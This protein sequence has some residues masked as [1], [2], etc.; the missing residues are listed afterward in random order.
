METGFEHTLP[1]P[2]R[3]LRAEALET[4]REFSNSCLFPLQALRTASEIATAINCFIGYM[5]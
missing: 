5:F 4:G 1:A 2:G 3:R